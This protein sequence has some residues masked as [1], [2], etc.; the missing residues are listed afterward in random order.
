MFIFEVI[1][2]CSTKKENENGYPATREELFV[3]FDSLNKIIDLLY[4]KFKDDKNFNILKIKQL[5]KY[6]G[7][8]FIVNNKEI[9]N[10]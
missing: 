4:N 5:K 7:Y 8:K 9:K 10:D 1:Y 6:N 3:G 2:H